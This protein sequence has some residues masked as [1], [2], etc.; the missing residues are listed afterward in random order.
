[1]M[2]STQF[3]FTCRSEG[4]SDSDNTVENHLQTSVGLLQGKYI[5][6]EVVVVVV[7]TQ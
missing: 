7:G 1:M 5:G 2:C 3:L 6:S 4:L